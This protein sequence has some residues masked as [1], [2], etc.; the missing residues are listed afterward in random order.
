MK[1]LSKIALTLII[2]GCIAALIVGEIHNVDFGTWGLVAIVGFMALCL[3][4]LALPWI[5]KKFHIEYSKKDGLKI[6]EEK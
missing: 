5:T 1:Y 3:V 2:F 6:T 4:F